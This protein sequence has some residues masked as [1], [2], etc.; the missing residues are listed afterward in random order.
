MIK[1][2]ALAAIA[3][4]T[5]AC[6][7]S[8]YESKPIQNVT[9]PVKDT[10]PPPVIPKEQP[11]E[12]GPAREVSFPPIAWDDL[13]TGLRVATITNATLPLVQI[14]FV[15]LGGKSLDGEK[16]GLAEITGDMLK[17]GGAGGLSG[18][19]FLAKLE[20]LGAQLSIDVGFD[21]T[22]IALTATKERLPA[23]FDL[24]ATLVTQPQFSSGEFDKLKKR[25]VDDATDAA[26][27]NPRWAASVV[28]YR[29]LF[30]LP[31][32]HHPYASFDATAQ[33]LAKLTVNDCR[34][35]H[36]KT[37]VAKNSFIV[38]A[39]D[40]KAA[41][42]KALADKAF[43]NFK[44]AEPPALSFTDPLPPEGMKITIVDRP[45]AQQSD[46][47]VAV[48]APDR[49]DPN[50]A[51]VT[52]TNQV[53]GGGPAA[54]LFLDVRE[55]RS[56]AYRTGSGLVELAHG[57]DVLVASAGTMTG[58]TGRA[59]QG[60]LENM[61]ALATTAP[62]DEEVDSAKKYLIDVFAIKMETVGSVADELVKV[63]SLGLGDDEPDRLRKALHDVTPAIV[64][65]TGGEMLRPGHAIV[66]V[67]GA[68]AR[69]EQSLSHFGEVKVLDPTKNFE[70]VRTVP[71]DATAALEEPKTEAP[72]Q[73]TP[74]TEAPKTEAPKQEA[75]K[76]APK[77]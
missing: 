56:L 50:W 22:T 70:R 37:F 26:R 11:P 60:L 41:D 19:D 58:K 8:T 3:F 30:A 76:D 4:V 44:G 57:P 5:I 74:K 23:L 18:K 29:D 34:A 53:L 49:K 21:K 59:L 16:P 10:A 20:A 55:K 69:I 45:K 31:S 71:M 39:G 52:V 67:S 25:R 66:V 32:E 15:A 14:R 47:L 65:K 75:P 36:R 1:H 72:K 24:L 42:V 51:A 62:S 54:R 28:L 43:A 13:P 6:T 2:G 35:L 48:L 9:I 40:T 12:A 64:N 68:A 17:E 73:E 33:D 63:K 46:V 38:V 77:P 61:D 7:S 27:N